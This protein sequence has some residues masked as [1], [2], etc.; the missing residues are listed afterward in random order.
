ME[1][2]CCMQHP[3]QALDGEDINKCCKSKKGPVQHRPMPSL[4]RIIRVVEYDD[5]LK[6]CCTKKRSTCSEG[7]PGKDGDPASGVSPCC[8]KFLGSKLNHKVVLTSS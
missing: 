4:I 5:T 2:E 6:H 1:Q 8:S 3:R 7:L